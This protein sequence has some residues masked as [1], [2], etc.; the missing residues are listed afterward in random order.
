MNCPKGQLLY[1]LGANDGDSPL[2][3][4]DL[5][6]SEEWRAK[7]KTRL[8]HETCDVEYAIELKNPRPT[9]HLRFDHRY[10]WK[11]DGCDYIM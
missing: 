8:V 7:T 11:C 5:E 2:V 3:E 10:N 9:R 1:I 6:V 4:F